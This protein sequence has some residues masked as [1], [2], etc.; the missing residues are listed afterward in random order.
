[1]TRTLLLELA[2]SN[3]TVR[4]S[5]LTFLFLKKIARSTGYHVRKEV[6]HLCRPA[7]ERG[8]AAEPQ[9]GKPTKPQLGP[10]YAYIS[11]KSCSLLLPPVLK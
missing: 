1:M 7:L 3:L 10:P 9:L 8:W 5:M 2:H 6:R 11:L 4:I